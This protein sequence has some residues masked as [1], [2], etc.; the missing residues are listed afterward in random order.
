ME[1][2]KIHWKNWPGVLLIGFAVA[3]PCEQG[4][5]PLPGR[6]RK[7]KI[8]WRPQGERNSAK[9]ISFPGEV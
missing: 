9:S 7:L 4:S 6:L 3:L 8:S 5:L 2:I 1:P